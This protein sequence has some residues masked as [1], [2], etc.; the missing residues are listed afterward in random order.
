MTGAASPPFSCDLAILGAG[1]AGIGAALGAAK[2]GRNFLLLEAGDRA[3]GVARTEIISGG[4]IDRAAHSTLIRDGKLWTL[5]EQFELTDALIAPARE[6]SARLIRTHEQRLRKLGPAAF[7]GSLFTPLDLLRLL[8]E[9]FSAWQRPAPDTLADYVRTRLGENFYRRAFFPVAAGIFAG[10]PEKLSWRHA[11]PRLFARAGD[12]SLL[13]SLF[14][15][16]P[17][18]RFKSRFVAGKNGTGAWLEACAAA[19]PAGRLRLR[20]RVTALQRLPEGGYEIHGENESGKFSLLTP[21][22]ICALDAA[23]AAA[24][25]TPL[26]A[27]AASF[28]EI[29]FAPV[30]LAH[31]R[32]RS[33]DCSLP[34]ALGYLAAADAPVG[35]LGVLFNSRMF[36]VR[37]PDGEESFTAFFG[38]RCQPEL[39][40]EDDAVLEKI[41]IEEMRALGLT[42]ATQAAHF[43]LSRWPRA[44]PQYEIGHEKFIAA[45][46][47]YE[48]ANPGLKIAGNY[49]YGAGLGEVMAQGLRAV[50]SEESKNREMRETR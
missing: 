29:P 17:G 3:G 11:F 13:L 34:R 30:A 47:A 19:L 26:N 46:K 16:S 20:H 37:A 32:L 7:L 36:P 14:S 48:A 4:L 43:T 39:A 12:G 24:L 18:L 21:Q 31:L 2:A 22:I 41:L 6:A 5:L 42:T 10:D 15:A 50:R 9:P 45:A 38:G 28:A 49:L 35:S 8:A 33:A 44:I 23:S 25:L 40:R 27:Q 1:A